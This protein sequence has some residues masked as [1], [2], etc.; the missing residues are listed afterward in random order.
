M[1]KVL[2]ATLIP[3]FVP[4]RSY[5]RV[6]FYGFPR[7]KANL[8]RPIKIVGER[9][10]HDSRGKLPGPKGRRPRTNVRSTSNPCYKTYVSPW[11]KL[12]RRGKQYRVIGTLRYQ[13]KMFKGPK[14]CG[15]QMNWIRLPLKFHYGHIGSGAKFPKPKRP[16]GCY[17]FFLQSSRYSIFRIVL[18]GPVRRGIYRLVALLFSF[19]YYRVRPG[20]LRSRPWKYLQ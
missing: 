1:R 16:N 17:S 20:L 11:K 7:A 8:T 2:R 9:V 14:P 4:I 5:F 10:K 12:I 3:K 15:Y 19:S 13:S 18:N 6:R